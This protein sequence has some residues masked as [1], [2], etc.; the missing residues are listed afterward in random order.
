MCRA[1]RR[2]LCRR[3]R[4]RGASALTCAALGEDGDTLALLLSTHGHQLHQRRRRMAS[5]AA[6]AAAASLT[7]I[8]ALVGA[9]ADVNALSAD[10][11]TAPILHARGARCGVALI[12]VHGAEVPTATLA[13]DGP[14]ACT[15]LICAAVGG[16]L[17]C[18]RL[19]AAHGCA[20]VPEV[21]SVVERL[22]GYEIAMRCEHR[23]SDFSDKIL[24]V[25]IALHTQMQRW[26]C[27]RVV[28]DAL[29]SW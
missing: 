19:L 23:S 3:A 11:L 6:A 29:I 4:R 13:D 20:G 28:G 24:C 15:P 12:E 25:G 26:R 2:R 7:G 1:A 14:G 18:V 16:E 22:H 21:M 17:D 27:A 9:G 10:G 5:T 8:A